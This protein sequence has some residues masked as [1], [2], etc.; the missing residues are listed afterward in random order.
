MHAPRFSEGFYETNAVRSSSVSII[1]NTP[2]NITGG[3]TVIFSNSG[4]NYSGG[5]NIGNGSTLQ[6]N[7]VSALSAAGNVNLSGNNST[8]ALNYTDSASTSTYA[9]TI[10]FQ[11][12]MP[13]I[14]VPSGTVTLNGALNTTTAGLAKTGTGTL[15][16][17]NAQATIASSLGGGYNGANVHHRRVPRDQLDLRPRPRPVVFGG[18]APRPSTSDSATTAVDCG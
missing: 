6:V 10:V 5:T 3:G 8:L 18:T 14:S 11:S 2:V 15:V 9:G 4:N 17:G 13:A 7:N 12:G 16:L 1:G